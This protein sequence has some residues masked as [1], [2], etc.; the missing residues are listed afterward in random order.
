MYFFK[1]SGTLVRKIVKKFA[2][3]PYILINKSFGHH[4]LE[5]HVRGFEALAK[6]KVVD[7]IAVQV[8][9]STMEMLCV[10]YR[11]NSI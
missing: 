11:F 10:L 8:K 5:D 4:S 9:I 2:V 7:V 3:S 6:T 1:I